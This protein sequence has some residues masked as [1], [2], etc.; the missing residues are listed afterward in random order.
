MKSSTWA[1]SRSHRKY[2]IRFLI[3]IVIGFSILG[4]NACS[5]ELLE[6]EQ[7]NTVLRRDFIYDED[8]IMK[9]GADLYITSY[10]IA[11]DYP[12]C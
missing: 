2:S 8:I 5:T 4:F 11:Y 6:T 12:F 9:A 3:V 7:D 1:H 10:I